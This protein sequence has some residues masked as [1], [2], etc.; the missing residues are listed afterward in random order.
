MSDSGENF[1]PHED[2]PDYPNDPNPEHG[3]NTEEEKQEAND[4][5]DDESA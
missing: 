3:A 1:V 4:G 5:S 2:D